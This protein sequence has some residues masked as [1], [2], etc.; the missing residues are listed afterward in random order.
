MFINDYIEHWIHS[1]SCSIGFD[2][3]IYKPYTCGTNS[4]LNSPIDI[5]KCYFQLI[6][7]TGEVEVM[8]KYLEDSK[9]EASLEAYWQRSS[10]LIVV[11]VLVILFSHLLCI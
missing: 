4:V 7:R 1:V 6:E 3:S 9:T 5:K 10:M 2:G 11:N 8:Y